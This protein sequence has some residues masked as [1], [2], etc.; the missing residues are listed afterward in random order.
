[1]DYWMMSDHELRRRSAEGDAHAQGELVKR[2]RD[3]NLDLPILAGRSLIQ[4]QNPDGLLRMSIRIYEDSSLDDIHQHWWIIKEWRRRLTEWQRHEKRPP[5]SI[6]IAQIWKRHRQRESYR[7]IAEWANQMIGH[8]LESSF[9]ATGD[10]PPEAYS[11]W[12]ESLF[13]LETLGM[14]ADEAEEWCRAG[15]EELQG[16]RPPFLPNGG[17]ISGERVR[18]YLRY[19]RKV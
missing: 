10:L 7:R 16:G 2:F 17:P 12:T 15:F 9:D 6:V 18:E 19:H 8:F 13:V 14:S 4:F 11:G 1:M 3:A 5:A